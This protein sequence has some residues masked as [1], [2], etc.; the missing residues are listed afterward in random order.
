MRTRQH[1]SGE[2]GLTLM[3]LLVALIVLSIGILSIGALFP[4]GTRGQVQDRMMTTAN[5]YAQQKLEEINNLVW[6][7][8]ALT[9]GRHPAGTAYEELGGGRWLR[10]YEVT[11]MSPPLDNLRKVVVTV[12]YTA[13]R[14]RSVTST[15]YVRR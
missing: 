14:P 12:Q 3:E 11:A 8:P 4:S 9:V 1:G 7:D 6:S 15:T 2:R 5:F 10:S 13:L